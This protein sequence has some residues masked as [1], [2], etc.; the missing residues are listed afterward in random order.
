MTNKPKLLCKAKSFG[1]D[2]RCVLD[3]I[4]TELGSWTGEEMV[5]CPGCHTIWYMDALKAKQ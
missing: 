3:N 5:I 2:C 4:P 1:G